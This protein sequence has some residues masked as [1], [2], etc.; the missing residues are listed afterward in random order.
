MRVWWV[1]N[2]GIVPPSVTFIEGTV[3]SLQEEGGCVTG[4]QYRQ[5]HS[6]EVK[7]SRPAAAVAPSPRHGLNDE[8]V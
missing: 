2:G 3:T 7:V 6:G 5:K 4:V 1:H 8:G